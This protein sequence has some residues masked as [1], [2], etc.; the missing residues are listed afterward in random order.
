M[1]VILSLLPL[2]ILNLIADTI[3][4]ADG[5]KHLKPL[6]LT[7]KKFCLLSQPRMFKKF[8]LDLPKMKQIYEDTG[9]RSRLQFPTAL[10]YVQKLSVEAL[11]ASSSPVNRK[12]LEV[13]WL[14]TQVIY[15]RIYNWYFQDFDEQHIT[16]LLG[17]F[18]T[19]VTQLKLL[20]GFFDS[21]VLIF[22]TSAFPLLNDLCVNP[23]TFSEHKTYKVQNADRSRT[24]GFQGMLTF[25]HLSKLHDQFLEFVSQESLAVHSISVHHCRSDGKLQELFVRLGGNLFNINVGM[26]GRGGKFLQIR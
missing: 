14:F 24:I 19:T 25:R 17:H 22:I 5:P 4:S 10:S 8:S 21:E 16:R 2:D 9:D 7:S 26:V 11:E 1:K 20:E 6:S 3:Y 23:R 18:G 15:L 13:L 12:Y